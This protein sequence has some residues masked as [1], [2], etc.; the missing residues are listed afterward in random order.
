MTGPQTSPGFGRKKF[1]P[2]LEPNSL[3]EQL[4]HRSTPGLASYSLIDLPC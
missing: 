1:L 3:F 4:T 2:G